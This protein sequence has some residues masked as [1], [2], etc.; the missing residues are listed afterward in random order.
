MR[1]LAALLTV[2]ATWTAVAI[3]AITW[4]EPSALTAAAAVTAIPITVA[5]TPRNTP[6]SGARR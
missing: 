2:L 6:K 5:L 4:P 1:D 3:T